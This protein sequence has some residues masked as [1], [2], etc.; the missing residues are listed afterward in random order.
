MKGLLDSWHRSRD[1]ERKENRIQTER[2]E[3]Y[4][5]RE[6]KERKRG[7][8]RQ[9]PGRREEEEEEE[10]ISLGALTTRVQYSLSR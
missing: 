1:E 6:E 8:S 3:W 2:R 7:E 4:G 5:L 9:N 10:E